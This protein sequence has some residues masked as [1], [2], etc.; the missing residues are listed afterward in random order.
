MRCEFFQCTE[1][2]IA[3]RVK[4]CEDRDP[5]NTC[6]LCGQTPSTSDPIFPK[7]MNVTCSPSLQ[8]TVIEVTKTTASCKVVIH[9]EGKFCFVKNDSSGG[10]IASNCS[11]SWG[12][13]DV[14]RNNDWHEASIASQQFIQKLHQTQGSAFL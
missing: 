8:G 7:W 5:V 11:C 13:E 6:Q 14:F 2:I 10:L 12:R 9:G 3:F 4:V 1:V